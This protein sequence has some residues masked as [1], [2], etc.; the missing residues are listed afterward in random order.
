MRVILDIPLKLYEL[1][2]AV[3]A[4]I[5]VGDK[6]QVNAITTDTRECC[7]GDLFIA[8]QGE[9]SSGELHVGEALKKGCYVISASHTNGAFRVDDSSLAL[10]QIASLYKSKINIKHTI[11]VTGS[12]GK[13]TTVKF[14]NRILSEKFVTHLPEGNLN[15][16]IGVPLT[17]LRAPISTEILITEL[18]MNHENEIAPLSRCVE[19]DIAIITSV[20]TAHIGNLGSR[21]NIAKAK[22]EIT[23]GMR[24]G[25]LI[26]PY[27]EPLLKGVENSIYVGRNTSLS[28]FSLNNSQ[29]VKYIFKSPLGNIHNIA[30]FDTRE[31]LLQDLSFAIS[32]SLLL[33]MMPDEIIRGVNAIT[34]E[35]LRQRFI[36]LKDFTI[37][38]DSYNASIESIKADID[39]LTK[40]GA[41]TGALL[42]DILELG[43]ESESI[44]EEVGR[45]V[46]KSGL[47]SLYLIGTY[48]EYTARGAI[49]C[50]MPQ[51]RIFINTDETSYI[52]TFEQI[53][54]GHVAGEIILFKASHKLRL[55]KIAD[56]FAEERMYYD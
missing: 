52:K 4:N 2:H 37:F 33:G 56:I 12:V 46:A 21:E 7:R 3:G 27:D 29:D 54:Y 23:A 15:N 20:G 22:L 53:K 5:V 13:S 35:D 42:G 45:I 38:D 24:N 34:K 11:A 10:M 43:K 18:G 48:A 6:E 51:N 39:Y 16:H 50:G 49:E 8:L 47:N 14:I 1:L 55:D 19:P 9:N 31:H 32:A 28:A 41:P 36:K 26:L 25:R 44:H 40:F 17:L 30:F